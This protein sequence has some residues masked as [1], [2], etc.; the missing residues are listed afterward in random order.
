MRHPTSRGSSPLIFKFFLPTAT[1]KA[2]E[3]MGEQG[4][5]L[6]EPEQGVGEKSVPAGHV[7]QQLLEPLSQQQAPQDSPG[8]F[9]CMVI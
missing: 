4:G 7:Q 1:A 6:A 5:E 2:L 8:G 9:P 3:H